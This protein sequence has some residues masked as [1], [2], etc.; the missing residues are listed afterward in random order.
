MRGFRLFKNGFGRKPGSICNQSCSHPHRRPPG[1]QRD[2]S[3]N[4][5]PENRLLVQELRVCRPV[6]A[7]AGGGLIPFLST[8]T[9]GSRKPAF[10]F[11]K[12][13][14]PSINTMVIF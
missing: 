13:I 11:L 5:F 3:E 7:M 8:Q 10:F 9:K 14:L 12:R 2:R 4:L 6:P 1:P